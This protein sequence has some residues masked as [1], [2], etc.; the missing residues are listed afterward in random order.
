MHKN[1]TA[2]LTGRLYGLT[3]LV[4]ALALTFTKLPEQA[5]LTDV[6][7]GFAGS[8]LRVGLCVAALYTTVVC[9]GLLLNVATRNSRFFHKHI[10][11]APE[12]RFEPVA[13]PTVLNA[14]HHEIL[15]NVKSFWYLFPW[16]NRT[17]ILQGCEQASQ[18]RSN[19]TPVLLV[20]GFMC[21][22]GVWN[23]LRPHLQRRGITSHSITCNPLGGDIDDFAHM[24]HTAV[25]ELQQRTGSQK[26]RMIG[27]SM[28]GLMIRAYVKHYGEQHI[29]SALCLGAPHQGTIYSLGG[30]GICAKQMNLGN[31][32]LM[33]MTRSE[34]DIAF[35]RKLTNICT[36]LEDIVQPASSAA[37]PGAR[38]WMV[39]HCGH[40]IMPADKGV[41]SLIDTWLEEVT[42]EETAV[43]EHAQLAA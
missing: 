19:T 38:N 37:L 29:E 42:Q 41:I 17:G 33:S 11:V 9:L 5:G 2:S 26:V 8:L 30:Q 31:P 23:T 27:H 3:A 36:T 6:V 39:S 22:A 32:W 34:T 16:Q 10:D 40:T 12:V 35:R 1:M 13:L 20:H 4:V 24:M 14:L 7:L 28:G 43:Q 25:L 21:N 18:A 15:A